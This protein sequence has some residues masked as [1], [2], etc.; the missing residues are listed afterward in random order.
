MRRR[1]SARALALLATVLMLAV[2]AVA[3][4]IPYLTRERKA[5][6][7]VPVPEPLGVQENIPLAQGQE[8]C[9]DEVAIDVDAEI[10]EFT[11]ITKASSGP[12]L[13]VSAAAPGYSAAG[14]V[15]GG[16]RRRQTTRFP[17]EP[18]RVPFKPPNRSLLAEFCVENRG[19]RRVELLA[20][21]DPRTA[22]RPVARVDGREV[23]PDLALRFL[24]EDNGSVL[25]RLGS[26]V[27]RMSAFHPAV[28]EKPVLWLLIV[29]LVLVLPVAAIYALV[30]S[31][32]ADR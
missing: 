13:R 6:A 10:A 28:L 23:A 25:A 9:L 7:G 15:E 20:A 4:F 1:P 17:P 27:D 11:V 18:L 22:S 12:P 30:S 32:R 8:A 5:V 14:E 3:V 16:Y 24:S 19:D 29:L 26:L 31:F 21:H 2:A